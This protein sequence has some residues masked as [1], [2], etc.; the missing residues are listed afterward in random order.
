MSTA[1]A[2]ATA[3]GQT[4]PKRHPA[5]SSPWLDFLWLELTSRCNLECVH[6][7]T[8][9]GP[10]RG[11]D[12]R[13]RREDYERLIDEAFDL[14]CRHVQFIGGE[15]QL[16]PDLER[17]T[18]H[19]R[20]R[21]YVFTEVYSNLTRLDE[22]LAD[23]ARDGSVC[24]ATSVYSHE[25]SRHDAITRRKDSHAR[26]VTNISRLVARGATV[27]AGV[28]VV[29]QDD[30]H[31]ARTVGFLRD[32]GVASV[33]VDRMRPYGRGIAGEKAERSLT[34]LCGHCW[35]GKLCVAPDGAAYPCVMSRGLPVGNVLDTSLREIV[36]GQRLRHA[37]ALIH[38]KVWAPRTRHAGAANDPCAPDVCQPNTYCSPM[39]PCQPMGPCAPILPCQP[40][41]GG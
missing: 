20:R 40:H 4:F 3:S 30:A 28:V 39:S 15:P 22:R 34:G 18:R 36:D 6:C 21:G 1:S 8:E 19:A 32:L 31:V 14:G 13:L 12:D 26:T 16:N 24:F 17:L 7:Y 41:T 5:P 9:S 11:E 29:D 25:P 23:L 38:D 37:R 2:A 10:H 33:R 35:A 27:R